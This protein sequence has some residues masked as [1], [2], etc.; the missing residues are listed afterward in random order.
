VD[1]PFPRHIATLFRRI[2]TALIAKTA[3]GRPIPTTNATY[4]VRSLGQHCP[5][6]TQVAGGRYLASRGTT[7]GLK[8]RC[9]AGAGEF[10]TR[11]RIATVNIRKLMSDRRRPR[12]VSTARGQR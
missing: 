10:K 5:D 7:L 12:Y 2:D 1:G 9:H 3:A 8:F 11:I 6:A 4:G